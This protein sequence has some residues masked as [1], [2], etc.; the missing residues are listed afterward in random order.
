MTK[1]DEDY[2]LPRKDRVDL[3]HRAINSLD[4][5]LLDDT[6]YKRNRLELERV[7]LHNKS[8]KV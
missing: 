4:K 3:L 7:R 5:E 2:V 8:E 6:I 1:I